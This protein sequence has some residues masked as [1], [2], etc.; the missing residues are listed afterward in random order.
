MW[1]YFIQNLFNITTCHK[2]REVVCLSKEEMQHH[3]APVFGKKKGGPQMA[4]LAAPCKAAFYIDA[5][6]ESMLHVKSDAVLNALRS[7]REAEASSQ[8][9]ARLRRLDAQIETLRHKGL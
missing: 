9:T 4:V 3:N 6:D 1:I 5:R 8:D 7:I 2:G